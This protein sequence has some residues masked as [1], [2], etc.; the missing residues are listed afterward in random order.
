MYSPF[1]AEKNKASVKQKKKKKKAHVIMIMI[2]S[3]NT[4]KALKAVHSTID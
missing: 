2:P 1:Q 4:Y 3:A